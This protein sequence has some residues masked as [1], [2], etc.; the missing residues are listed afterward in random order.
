MHY[1]VILDLLKGYFTYQGSGILD[2]THMR[3]FTL[4]EVN[5]MFIQ[6]GYKIS[7]LEASLSELPLSSADKLLFDELVKLPGIA[8]EDTFHDY[9]YLVKATPVI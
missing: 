9:Q 3:F 2:R 1:T 7:A 4:N 5:R 8:P 6:C